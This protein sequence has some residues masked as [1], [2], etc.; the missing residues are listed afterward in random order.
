LS[1]AGQGSPCLDELAEIITAQPA[2]RD[3]LSAASQALDTYV[4]T[5]EV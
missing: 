5:P 4:G 2:L 3:F 1:F